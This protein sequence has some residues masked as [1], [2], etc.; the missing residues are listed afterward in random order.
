MLAKGGQAISTAAADQ[1]DAF[2]FAYPFQEISEGCFL[3]R[4]F[5]TVCTLPEKCIGFVK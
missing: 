1:D 4:V 2:V 3:L 5:I